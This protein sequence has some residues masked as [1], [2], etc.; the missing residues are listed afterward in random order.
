MVHLG[1]DGFDSF[2]RPEEDGQQ[3]FDERVTG[4]DC[5]GE[6]DAQLQVWVILKLHGFQPMDYPMV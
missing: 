6:H 3:S 2:L 5:S 1:R 4:Q